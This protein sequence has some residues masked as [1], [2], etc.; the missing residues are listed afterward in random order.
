MPIKVSYHTPI[1]TRTLLVVRCSFLK[2]PAVASH[3]SAISCES[4]AMACYNTTAMSFGRNATDIDRYVKQD[5]QSFPVP[6]MVLISRPAPKWTMLRIA[7]P[8][9]VVKVIFW[10]SCRVVGSATL[11]PTN[12]KMILIDGMTT[13]R[14][15]IDKGKWSC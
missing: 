2:Q 3:V 12:T 4:F 11:G 8:V 10:K 6:V 14:T 15:V 7:D 1:H 9:E 13:V 5:F